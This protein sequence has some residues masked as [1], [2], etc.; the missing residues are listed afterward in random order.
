MLPDGTREERLS[1]CALWHV[2]RNSKAPTPSRLAHCRLSFEE[3]GSADLSAGCTVLQCRLT[4]PIMVLHPNSL[5]V[6]SRNRHL[7]PSNDR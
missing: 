6:S 7:P 2:H 3:C 1:R 4:E 5:A